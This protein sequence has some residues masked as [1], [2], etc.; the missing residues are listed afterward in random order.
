M[1]EIP[2]PALLLTA[3]LFAG[4]SST[5]VPKERDVR[6]LV[7]HGQFDE[8][9]RVAAQDV[10]ERP[11][12][13]EAVSLHREA[14]VAWHLER[15][16]RATFEDQDDV[17]NAA[18]RD[19]LAI[20]PN[21][22]EAADWLRKTERKVAL[23]ELGKALE[24]HANDQ[25]PEA[26]EHYEKAL[27][28]DPEV[29]GAKQGRELAILLLRYRAGLGTR[30]FKD[31]LHAYSDYWLEYARSRFSYAEKYQTTDERARDRKDQVQELLAM[32]RLAAGRTH[33]EQGR[34]GAAHGEYRM[35]VLLDPENEDAKAALGRAKTELKVT[36]KLKLAR[37]EIVRG[38]PEKAQKLAEEAIAMTTAQ[39]DLA[40]G[41]LA[42][43]RES[44]F[45]AIYRDAL[46]LER[47]WRFEEAAAR[48]DDL[49]VEAQFYKD[50]IARRD[51]LQEYVRRASELYAKADA[52][53]TPEEQLA[54]LRQIELFWP[55]YRD[56]P[57][58]I[59]AL[60]KPPGN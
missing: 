8:A 45:E 57:V 25:I 53:G 38:R 48:Y 36:E 56:V 27:A 43:L 3:A 23:R 21:A 41:V 58:R 19:A 31:G 44:R 4:C 17:A 35:A 39:K 18:F 29:P 10:Q 26:V 14:S 37:I 5:S 30:Y 2:F 49:L 33:E 51:T 40:D 42:E 28:A 6:W 59:R 11:D 32:Q 22:V 50:S 24:L 20:D 16:R 47:D 15:G 54:S 46:A 9:V 7:Y 34:F 12:D 1:Q 60:E 52:A 55:E 13:P